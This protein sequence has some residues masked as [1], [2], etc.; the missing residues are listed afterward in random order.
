MKKQD[1]AIKVKNNYLVYIHVRPDTNHPFYVGKGKIGRE[2]TQQSRNRH[3]WEIVNKNNGNFLVVILYENLS[4]DEALINERKVELLLREN[5][6]PLTNILT[7][8]LKV[9]TYGLKHTE[10]TI[11]KMCKPKS[12]E[13]AENISKGKMGKPRPEGFSEKIK[14]A[15]KGKKK[16]TDEFKL[17]LSKSISKKVKKYSILGEFIQEYHSMLQAEIENHP[18]GKQSTNISSCIKGSQKTAYGFKWSL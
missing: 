12:K 9:G 13:H 3:W 10:E 8:G 16:H 7:C 6:I 11:K 18:M 15:N 1:N 4:E 14:K 5:E 2:K 17:K